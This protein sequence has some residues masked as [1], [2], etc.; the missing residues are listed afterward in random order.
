MSREKTHSFK[1]WTIKFASEY[2]MIVS[3]VVLGLM[4]VYAVVIATITLVPALPALPWEL[5]VVLGAIVFAIAGVVLD[6]INKY[7]Q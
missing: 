4:T 1:H 6:W 3:I 5:K 2:L 7:V